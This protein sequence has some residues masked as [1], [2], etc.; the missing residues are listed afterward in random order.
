MLNGD[1]K[2]KKSPLDLTKGLLLKYISKN[3]SA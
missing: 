2:L 3:F 1:S